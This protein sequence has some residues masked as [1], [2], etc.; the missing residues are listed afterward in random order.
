MLER[1]QVAFKYLQNKAHINQGVDSRHQRGMET[2]S[3]HNDSSDDYNKKNSANTRPLQL[4]HHSS[5]DEQNYQCNQC[6]HNLGCVEGEGPVF[7]ELLR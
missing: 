3:A 1:P 4:A 6:E 2:L 5:D 7:A